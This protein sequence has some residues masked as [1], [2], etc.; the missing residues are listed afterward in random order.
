M[1]ASSA[2]QLAFD[3]AGAPSYARAAFLPAECNRH[4][5]ERIAGWRDWP[6]GR[7]VLSGPEASGK[8]HLA[9]VWAAEAGAAI[10]AADALA[11]ADVAAL[12]TGREAVEDADRPAREPGFERA[13]FHLHNALRE[14][15]GTLLLT[16]RAEPGRWGT[17]LP[18][19][20]SRIEA[21]PHVRLAPPDDALLAAVL[22][23]LFDDR[24]LR[25]TPRLVDWLV[26]RMDR[27]LA[28]A[29]EIV[30]RL[31][32]AALAARAPITREMAAAVLDMPPSR[33]R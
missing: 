10:V 24:Q 31:D 27:S 26:L 22:V 3:L 29:R 19:L 8:T 32:A 20:A 16:A 14:A 11:A 13:L 5:L 7:M 2:R 18:D 21:A 9:H 25:V 17:A 23:K 12:A 1:A 15:G 4:A 33:D 6:G 28:A 30:A